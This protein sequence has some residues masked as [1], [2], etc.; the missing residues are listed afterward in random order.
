MTPEF[1]ETEGVVT[2]NDDILVT[3]ANTRKTNREV[4]I[5]IFCPV[6]QDYQGTVWFS[7]TQN[8]AEFN[9]ETM[10]H[11]QIVYVV[12]TAVGRGG[13]YEAIPYCSMYH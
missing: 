9:I 10:P 5:D 6:N 7:L 11:E 2:V 8:C 3:L 1:D 13:L 12:E 4:L